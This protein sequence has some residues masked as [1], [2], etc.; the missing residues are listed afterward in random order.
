[1]LD[2]SV[3]GAG[4]LFEVGLSGRTVETVKP[5]STVLPLR[6]TSK[7]SP[8]PGTERSSIQYEASTISSGSSGAVSQPLRDRGK[9]LT[10]RL[11]GHT[12]SSQA[13]SIATSIVTADTSGDSN[14]ARNALRSP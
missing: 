8:A 12:Q 14:A 6:P 1:M 2:L 7:S 4:E 5:A 9:S 10:A 13:T 3:P 11:R